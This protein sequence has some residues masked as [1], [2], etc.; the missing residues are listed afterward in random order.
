MVFFAVPVSEN[1]ATAEDYQRR[2]ALSF[3]DAVRKALFDPI[4]AENFSEQLLVAVGAQESGKFD[5]TLVNGNG[6]MQVTCG[7]GKK[8]ATE[9]G[10]NTSCDDN[11]PPPN[12]EA[13]TESISFNVQDGLLILDA[14]YLLASGPGRPIYCQVIKDE[15]GK[16]DEVITSVVY[17]NAWC[18]FLDKYKTP[19]KSEEA[20]YLGAVA[21]QLQHNPTGG[22]SLPLVGN[23]PGLFSSIL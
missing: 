10:A 13:T 7:S 20:G 17:Y 2:Q 9:L 1:L 15:N 23:N 14:A 5:N 21:N 3:R 11:P 8:G 18:D 4:Y 6:I 22:N 16:T 12:Y 19:P